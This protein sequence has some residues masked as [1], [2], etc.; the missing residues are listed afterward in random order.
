MNSKRYGLGALVLSMAMVASA[1]AAEEHP[2]IFD[3]YG[4][5]IV[6]EVEIDVVRG[7]TLSDN[8]IDR[9]ARSLRAVAVKEAQ[10]DY[11]VVDDAGPGVLQ[12]GRAHV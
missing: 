8:Y 11:V 5:V 2:K 12:I 4:H 6:E 9:L 3:S 7:T 10:V 1:V